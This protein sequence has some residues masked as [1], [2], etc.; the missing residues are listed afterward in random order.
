MAGRAQTHYTTGDRELNVKALIASLESAPVGAG[1][2]LGQPFRALRWQR[3]FLRGAFRPGIQ[4]AGF[5][6]GRGGGKSGLA[7]ALALDSLRPAG[8]LLHV[9]GG[10]TIVLASSFALARIIFDAVVTSP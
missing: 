9:P 6:L 8:A 1:D 10:E 4:R 5:T 3:R 2:L 7:S